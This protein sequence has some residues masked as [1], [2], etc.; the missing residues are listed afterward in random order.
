MAKEELILG[1]ETSCDETAAAVVAQ[2]RTVL[3]NVISSQ[4]EWHKKFKGVVPE[5][6]SR[7]HIELITPIIEESL[8]EAGIDFID[9]KAIAVTQGPGL[10]G[11]LLVG[12]GVAKALSYATGIPCVG[13]NH[14]EGHI[15]ANFLESLHLEFPF[16]ALV[17]SGG[18]TSLIYVQDH[19]VYQILGET[20]DDAA[21]EAFDKIA[22]FLNL[23]YPGGPAI[24]KL[25]KDG[26]PEAIQFPRAMLHTD[27]YNFS[28]SGIKTAV[29]N[30][31]AKEKKEG[32]EVS[33]PDLAAS[34][35]AAVLEVQV[36]K[37]IKA[38]K[39]KGVKKIVLGG[40]V[41]A[42]SFLRE[43]LKQKASEEEIDLFYP[44]RKLC[45]DNGVMIA[46]AGYYRFKQGIFLNLDASP[47][48]NLSL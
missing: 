1:I 23:G 14:L 37:T 13:I 21:G 15:Y 30:Y 29:L 11:A 34:F 7:K 8:I 31:V 47:D 24:D 3:S 18:H 46:C 5:I 9:L 41:A 35:E 39:D 4:V 40:G 2:G 10:V 45:T 26:N 12:M 48:P 32:K 27:D 36:I 25:A 17:V 42:N 38:A 33:L 16:V 20:L 43:S 6:A 22:G 44:S 28:L 19:G